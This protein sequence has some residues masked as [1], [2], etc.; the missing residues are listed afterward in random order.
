MPSKKITKRK[1][2]PVSSPEASHSVGYTLKGA[3]FGAAIGII[4]SLI[5]GAAL[6][7][8]AMCFSD[9][10]SLTRTFAMISLYVSSLIAGLVAFKKC[11][12]TPFMCGLLCGGTMMLFYLVVSFFTPK[13]DSISDSFLLTLLLRLLVIVS[14][15]LGAIVGRRSSSKAHRPKR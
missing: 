5:L 4:I 14:A 12:D 3:L 15:M 10:A 1:K 11:G 6:S 9:P 13:Y 8:I 7:G 2:R